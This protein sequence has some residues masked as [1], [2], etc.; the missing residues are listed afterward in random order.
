MGRLSADQATAPR[1]EPGQGFLQHVQRLQVPKGYDHMEAVQQV[2]TDPYRAREVAEV[3]GS[4]RKFSVADMVNLQ[5]YNLSIPARSIVPL[6]RFVEI[7]DPAAKAAANRLLHWDCMLD[8]D[9]VEAGIYEMFQRHLM[10]D[11]RATI[12]PAAAKPYLSPP[13]TRIIAS[14][15]APDESYGPDP[16][17]GRDQVIAKALGEA[18]ADLARRFGP[19]MEKWTLG[20]YHYAR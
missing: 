16:V 11:V 14:L 17:K 5:N 10:E 3:L 18:V 15:T 8:Q 13:M 2:W 7:G 9:S 20:S 6:L 4:G 1:A 12:V 19:D